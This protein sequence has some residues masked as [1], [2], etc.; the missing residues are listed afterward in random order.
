VAGLR[1]EDDYSWTIFI[2]EVLELL[3]SKKRRLENHLSASEPLSLFGRSAGTADEVH[4]IT[5]L[6][7]K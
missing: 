3:A 6:S 7:L 4:L 1:G 5:R 2:Q